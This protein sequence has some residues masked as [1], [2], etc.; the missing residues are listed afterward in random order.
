[1][2]INF[3]FREHIFCQSRSITFRTSSNRKMQQ[4][5]VMKAAN[6]RIRA[7]RR[8]P[9]RTARRGLD[10]LFYVSL[11]MQTAWASRMVRDRVFRR[12]SRKA[13]G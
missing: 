6:C 7:R 4:K 10:L 9:R 2:K 1:M 11:G 12:S 13:G 3:R 8:V 5:L